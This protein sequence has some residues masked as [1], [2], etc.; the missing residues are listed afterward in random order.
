MDFRLCL[1][2]L[3]TVTQFYFSF[4]NTLF[5]HKDKL[6]GQSQV[7]KPGVKRAGEIKGRSEISEP[8][9]VFTTPKTKLRHSHQGLAA[10]I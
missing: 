9:S 10:G 2:P 6:E 7:N 8:P 1:K 3:V 5:L 4:Y